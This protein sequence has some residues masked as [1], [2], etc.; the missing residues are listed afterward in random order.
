MVSA[1]KTVKVTNIYYIINVAIAQ[2]ATK[3]RMTSVLHVQFRI[4]EVLATKNVYVV[5]INLLHYMKLRLIS[6]HA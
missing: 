1:L 3:V 4:I 5:L 2:S 6:Q